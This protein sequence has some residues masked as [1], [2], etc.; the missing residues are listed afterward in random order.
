MGFF[1]LK[2]VYVGVIKMLEFQWLFEWHNPHKRFH[3]FFHAFFTGSHLR[4]ILATWVPFAI[5]FFFSP[6]AHLLTHQVLQTIIPVRH[7]VGF[8]S[9]EGRG[10][11]VTL[12][13]VSRAAP[14]R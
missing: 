5:F 9:Q 12:A 4:G 14:D 8:Y 10:G 3:A 7:L 6:T 13:H 11:N 1:T 2:I